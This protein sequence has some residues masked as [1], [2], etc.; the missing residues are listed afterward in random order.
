MKK[1]LWKNLIAR[2]SGASDIQIIRAERFFKRFGVFPGFCGDDE[3]GFHPLAAGMR[4]RR[5][6]PENG[7]GGGI[8]DAVNP[9]QMEARAAHHF[10]KRGR[11]AG[12]EKD[13]KQAS[14][15]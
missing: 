2:P 9:P 4:I 8:A 12:M 5:D 3:I 11:A 15:R 7:L 13:E 6:C 1:F 10:S 14:G